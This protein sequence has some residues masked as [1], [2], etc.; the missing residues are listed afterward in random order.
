MR[1]CMDPIAGAVATI[2][3][4][5]LSAGHEVA[6]Y[7]ETGERDVLFTAEGFLRTPPVLTQQGEIIVAGDG[8]LHCLEVD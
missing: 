6:C 3:R 2:D 4:L 7:D 1:R 8:V 5:L